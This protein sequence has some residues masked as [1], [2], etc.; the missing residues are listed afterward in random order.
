TVFARIAYI[1][2]GERHSRPPRPENQ[3]DDRE[4]DSRRGPNPLRGEPSCRSR[5][6]ISSP[7]RAFSPPAISGAEI[8]GT[9]TF[10][11]IVPRSRALM[12]VWLTTP[13]RET[14]VE[15]AIEEQIAELGRMTVT[16]LRQKYAD[17]FGEETR[18]NN[19]QF[20]YRRIAWRIQA[21][22]EGG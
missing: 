22:A 8:A 4:A 2:N 18:S 1:Y 13:R 7:S 5:P 14:V 6:R 16:Q 21:L 11:L 12:G 19:K 17:V 15:I 9:A 10:H 3:R 20:L